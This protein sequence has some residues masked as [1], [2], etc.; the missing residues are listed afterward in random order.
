MV[1]RNNEGSEKSSGEEELY[2]CSAC[3]KEAF[4]A[5]GGIDT[6]DPDAAHIRSLDEEGREKQV[7]ICYECIQTDDWEKRARERRDEL[8]ATPPGRK[9]IIGRLKRPIN[10]LFELSPG[11]STASPDEPS[12]DE[13]SAPNRSGQEKLEWKLEQEREWSTYLERELQATEDR[14]R[15]VEQELHQLR[16]QVDAEQPSPSESVIDPQSE[17]LRAVFDVREALGQAIV[18]A[19]PESG[20]REGLARIDQQLLDAIEQEG[21]EQIDIR[22]EANPHRHR[23]VET[24]PTADHD[25]G[26]ILEEYKTGYQRGGVVI[27]PAHV[28]VA[29]DSVTDDDAA[30]SGAGDSP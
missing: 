13:Q 10:L 24:I 1:D 28:A 12:S 9:R 16:Q 25:P 2:T 3:G 26:T 17:L 22:G 18:S 5:G 30:G 20:F 29:T 21:I 27:R 7:T 4:P 11:D 19:E 15:E 14:L 8:D 6:L 23:V